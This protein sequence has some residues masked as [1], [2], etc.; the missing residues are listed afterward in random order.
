MYSINR[1]NKDRFFK[2][3][4]GDSENKENL[5]SLYNALNGTDYTDAGALEINTIEDV[6]YMGMAND[7]SCILDGTMMISEHQSS[8]NPNM[9]LRGLMYFGLLYNKYVETH[10]KNIYGERLVKI[11]NPK[12]YVLYNGDKEQP[13]EVGLKLSDA[14]IHEGK[15]VGYEWTATMLNINYGHNNDLLDACKTLKGYA[16]FVDKVKTCKQSGL[17]NEEAVVKAV[18]DCIEEGILSDYLKAHKAEVTQMVLTEYDE[19]KTMQ[20][21]KEEAHEEGRVEGRA[22]GKKEGKAEEHEGGIKAIVNSLSKYISDPKKVYEEVI[23]N[24]QY[25][26]VSIDDVYKYYG[27]LCNTIIKG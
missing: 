20:M 23:S 8:V 3:L 2:R 4:F 14:F 1:N 16:M 19:A 12:Y 22:E 13:D 18:D 25:S 5:L 17:S 24:P 9:P 11:P 15:S 10:N 27:E 7:V 26:D 21:L 6:I